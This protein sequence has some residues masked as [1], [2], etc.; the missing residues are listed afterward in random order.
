MAVEYNY[1][2]IFEGNILD[3]GQTSCG[4]TTFIQKIAENNF[5]ELEEIFWI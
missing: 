2:G 3:V 1:D 4:K 5:G